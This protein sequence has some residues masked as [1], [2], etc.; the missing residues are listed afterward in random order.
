MLV[1]QTTANIKPTLSLSLLIQVVKANITK[2]PN[3]KVE[4]ERLKQTHINLDE[5]TAN[6][7]TVT[8]TVQQKWGSE[9]IVV[10][11]DGLEV[12]NSSGTQGTCTSRTHVNSSS[13][14]GTLC[15]YCTFEL[16]D[17]KDY[18][19]YPDVYGFEPRELASTMKLRLSIVVL[20][21]SLRS[22]QGSR[23]RNWC[24]R[25]QGKAW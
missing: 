4:F 11:G 21:M 14:N 3:G 24:Q 7:H 5:R 17:V 18:S 15:N 20:M 22:T 8:N 13:K 6:V 12:E 2:L 19:K 1:S 16:I 10:T 23:M 9:F 25:E